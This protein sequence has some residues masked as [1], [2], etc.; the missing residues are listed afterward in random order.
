MSILM[1]QVSAS[2]YNP[3]GL[4]PAVAS[5]YIPGAQ[6][7]EIAYTYI[8]SVRDK[9]WGHNQHILAAL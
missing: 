1:E 8:K 2:N 4:M 9:P 5:E 7:V 6:W 3:N